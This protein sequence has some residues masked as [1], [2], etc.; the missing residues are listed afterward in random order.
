MR[1]TSDRAPIEDSWEWYRTTLPPNVS[2]EIMECL[3]AAFFV[4]AAFL[5]AE[6]ADNPPLVNV[7]RSEI[8][9]IARTLEARRQ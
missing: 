2:P 3:R 6:V 8:D 5:L 1:K 4:G 7:A 9:R